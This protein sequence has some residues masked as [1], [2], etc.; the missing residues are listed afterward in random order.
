[1][2][3]DNRPLLL[4]I[5]P[6]LALMTCGGAVIL[7]LLLGTALALGSSSIPDV[8]VNT[9]F[10]RDGKELSGSAVLFLSASPG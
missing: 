7:L 5:V 4:K 2:P 6:F 3:Q 10:S 8:S 1:V 9:T